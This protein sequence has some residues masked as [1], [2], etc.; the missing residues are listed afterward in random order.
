MNNFYFYINRYYIVEFNEGESH[1]QRIS[2]RVSP[3][4]TSYTAK[5]LKPYTSYRFR[6][7]ATNDIGSSS[8]SQESNITWT[9][10]A[11]I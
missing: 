6:I 3:T 2:E 1:W 7:Q 4:G 8:F 5:N 10:P 9:M 11:G